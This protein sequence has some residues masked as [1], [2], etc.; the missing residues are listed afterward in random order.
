MGGAAI[1]PPPV[2][3]GI[4]RVSSVTVVEAILGVAV[5]VAIV[6]DQVGA[7]AV[8]DADFVLGKDRVLQEGAGVLDVEASVLA[9]HHHQVPQRRPAAVQ[10]ERA[11]GTIAAAVAQ[12]YV[13]QR[14]TACRQSKAYRL[15]IARGRD[16]RPFIVV[17]I[18]ADGVVLERSE[19]NAMVGRALSQQLPVDG[20]LAAGGEL[21]HCPRLDGQGRVHRQGQAAV[22]H[23]GQ[24]G[25]PGGVHVD[26]APH[27][28]AVDPV[29]QS[30]VA[31]E[32]GLGATVDVGR[33]TVV[34][35]QRVVS[36]L[37]R[38]G[39]AD[40]Q[41][42]VAVLPNRVAV[43]RG[44]GDVD[45]LQPVAVAVF[46]AAVQDARRG[47]VE[48]DVGVGRAA[49]VVVPGPAISNNHV[50]QHSVR[51]IAGV[52]EV[53]RA[54][55][56]GVGLG[57]SAVLPCIAAVLVVVDG[58]EGDGI[59]DR[60]TGHQRPP[61]DEVVAGEELDHRTGLQ[62]QRAARLYRQVLGGD[63]GQV[64][65]PGAAGQTAVDT[66]AVVVVA[67]DGVA[68]EI[69][70]AV[71]LHI[72]GIGA[73]VEQRVAID[74]RGAG[75]GQVDAMGQVLVDL[76][77]GNLAGRAVHPAQAAGTAVADG[78]MGD[79]HRSAVHHHV[80][81][82]PTVCHQ[83]VVQ[84][85]PA[86][87]VAEDQSIPIARLGP[88]RSAVDIGVPAVG[89]IVDRGEDDAVI[90][91]PL[92]QERPVD[93]QF[94]LVGL[95]LELDHG[96][97]LNGER[98]PGIHRHPP[99][100]HVDV[101]R[102]PGG[103]GGDVTLDVDGGRDGAGGRRGA[104]RRLG[105]RRPEWRGGGYDTVHEEKR[106]AD[107]VVGLVFLGHLLQPVH[108]RPEA[109][110]AHSFKGMASRQHR[111]YTGSQ[112][113]LSPGQG[114]YCSGKGSR[115]Q[116]GIPVHQEGAGRVHDALVGHPK[117]HGE[118][119]FFRQDGGGDGDRGHQQVGQAHRDR[120]RSGHVVDLVALGYHV[121]AVRLCP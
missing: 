53:N 49:A 6:D 41:T 36:N 84:D 35:H 57:G 16:G 25:G 47:A 97:R 99:H 12:R 76:V 2:V 55:V 13:V 69:G 9:A 62:R 15:P 120:H 87:G 32:G 98:H 88:G 108:L 77:V 111:S 112:A 54:P 51:V 104:G 33:V 60:S 5:D 105:R 27:A 45:Q 118:R 56:A 4:E 74:G 73:V 19:D 91:R 42:V 58:G 7:C 34:A 48:G 80:P 113:A 70:P 92:G 100:H 61:H 86:G 26:A 101:V 37:W 63:V 89:V 75:T 11:G 10:V 106:R 22:H 52:G 67:V 107:D 38:G 96:A 121:G 93:G 114:A 119:C 66:D 21:D 3:G 81:I 115:R 116:V 78:G 28:D 23:V 39:G 29:T 20:H 8:V 40:P 18:A 14:R 103:V 46:E 68:T 1:V 117:C 30:D 85:A 44:G 90:G 102:C 31:A 64:G 109:A 71:A 72:D 79:V 94:A 110:D 24:V 65:V 59:G 17:G 50:V 43:N 82:A 95:L 83:H